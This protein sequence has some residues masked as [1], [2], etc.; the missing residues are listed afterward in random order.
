M[1]GG[2]GW[3]GTL[4][5]ICGTGE[6]ILESTGGWRGQGPRKLLVGSRG[7]DSSLGKY[8]LEGCAKQIERGE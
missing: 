8:T 4:Q 7:G 5:N 6:G 1:G 3:A 2:G